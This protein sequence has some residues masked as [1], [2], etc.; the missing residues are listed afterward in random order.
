MTDTT[1]I[2]MPGSQTPDP[3][4]KPDRP[5]VA[6]GAVVLNKNREVLLIKRG[7]PPRKGEWSLPG[8][9]VETGET[10]EHAVAREVREETGLDVKV[11]TWLMN[12]D[13]IVREED[14]TV[15]YHYVL[16]DYLTEVTGGT[17]QFGSDALDARF[18]P[19]EEAVN[20]VQWSETKAL[21]ERAVN[22]VSQNGSE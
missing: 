9:A 14:G 5:F 19:L 11:L 18:F 16:L 13:S 3:R 20:L 7:R 2:S 22:E 1:H 17:L 4:Y 21:L 12:V 8:G 10:I 15:A 6:V